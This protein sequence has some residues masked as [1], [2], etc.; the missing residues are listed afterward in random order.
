MWNSPSWRDSHSSRVKTMI[1]ISIDSS[2]QSVPYHDK[3]AVVRR[4]FGIRLAVKRVAFHF[5]FTMGTSRI[6]E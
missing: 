6:R 3:S 1:G 2:A 5:S 4:F